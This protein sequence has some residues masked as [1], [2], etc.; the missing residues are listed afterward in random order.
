MWLISHGLFMSFW[1]VK[2]RRILLIFKILRL[3]SEWQYASNN[4]N[5]SA[6]LIW[7]YRRGVWILW[8]AWRHDLIS[9]KSWF[10]EI[11]FCMICVFVKRI[12][13]TCHSEEWNDEESLLIFKILHLRSEWHGMEWSWPFRKVTVGQKRFKFYDLPY[14]MIWF[15][16]NHDL[17]K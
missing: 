8:F 1:G 9:P 6:K 4:P 11:K 16:R 7:I 5:H 12:N 2:R 10:A 3:R 15:L 14:G 17:Q 13:I